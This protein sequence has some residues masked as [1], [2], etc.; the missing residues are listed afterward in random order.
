ML[1]TFELPVAVVTTVMT[2][3]TLLCHT[4]T[5]SQSQYQVHVSL[6]LLLLGVYSMCLLSHTVSIGQL[7]RGHPT[8]L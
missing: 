5:S 4:L 1:S 7:A 8:L 6:L 2:T 3:L